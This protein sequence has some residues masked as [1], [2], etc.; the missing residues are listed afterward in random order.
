[1]INP[2]KNLKTHVERYTADN[3]VTNKS[4]AFSATGKCFCGSISETLFITKAQSDILYNSLC[5][6][7]TVED[8]T[9]SKRNRVL[10][11]AAT[12]KPTNV[13]YI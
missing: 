8:L 6:V 3:T 5:F 10:S 2:G 12:N 1:M 13:T 4:Q 9:I 11:L 7:T